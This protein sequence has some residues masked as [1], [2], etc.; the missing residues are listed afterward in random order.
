MYTS[1]GLINDKNIIFRDSLGYEF[2]IQVCGLRIQMGP[3]ISDRKARSV[4]K[5][6]NN[7]KYIINSITYVAKKEWFKNLS[8][9]IE[10]LTE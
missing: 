8:Q 4:I 10:E 6:I 1:N 7:S 9:M 2:D 5:F 3:F